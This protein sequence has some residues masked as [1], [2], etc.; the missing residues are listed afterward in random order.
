MTTRQNPNDTNRD[1]E[2]P[3]ASGEKRGGTGRS[4]MKRSEE[5]LP[6]NYL[7][8]EEEIAREDNGG[9]EE[10]PSPLAQCQLKVA[11]VVLQDCMEIG[12]ESAEMSSQSPRN[13]ESLQD[14]GDSAET[15]E[16]EFPW[17]K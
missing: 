11:A 16:T 10:N 13:R 1:G 7:P 3:P 8:R 4:E 14:R 17:R 12:E 5:R 2:T 9:D 6:D 15:A